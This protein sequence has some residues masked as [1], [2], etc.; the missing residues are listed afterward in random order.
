MIQLYID[1]DFL[2]FFSKLL[3]PPLEYM[4]K[5]RHQILP[6]YKKILPDN[7]AFAREGVCIDKYRVRKK[8]S[9]ED[10]VSESRN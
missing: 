6:E 4:Y 9:K 2:F 5:T 1:F 10:K 7:A 3:F 8:E